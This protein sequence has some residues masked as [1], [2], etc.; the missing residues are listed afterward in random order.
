MESEREESDLE[1]VVSV[2]VYSR[3]EVFQ[4]EL[5]SGRV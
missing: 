3:G 2:Q 1:S 4:N 5:T